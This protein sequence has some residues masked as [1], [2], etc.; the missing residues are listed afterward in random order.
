MLYLYA[1]PVFSF[2]RQCKAAGQP[3]GI[4]ATGDSDKALK[5]SR[6]RII[7]MIN[8]VPTIREH[9]LQLMNTPMC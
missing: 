5:Q 1:A 2:Y 9:E 6:H 3:Y 8:P 4:V 7:P